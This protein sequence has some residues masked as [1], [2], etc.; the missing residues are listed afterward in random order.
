MSAYQY[1]EFLAIDWPLDTSQQAE[2]R[3]LS[4]RA[5]ITA[6]SFVNEYHWGNF[7][8][9]PSRIMVRYYDAHLY[10]ANWGSRRIMLRLP[11]KLLDLDVAEQYCVGEQVTAWRTANHLIV[12]LSSEDDA[13]DWVDDAQDSLSTIVGVREELATGDLRSLYLAWLAGYAA[14]ERDEL[15]FDAADDELEPS[16]PPGL[17][18]LTAAQQ[19]L[20]DFLR[21]DK[22]LLDVA[23]AASPP[24]DAIADDP[25]RV[26]RRRHPTHRPT[27]PRRPQRPSRTLSPTAA[28]H[29]AENTTAS[30]ASSNASTR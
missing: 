4:T 13:G 17:T 1:F 24:R 12:D 10:L 21:L 28:W 3:A 15:A 30:P 29:C 14:W 11:R 19:A 25:R 16:V 26:R 18:T 9:D 2:V 5:R 27:R 6:T 8:G 20:A 22:D 7:H 23:A